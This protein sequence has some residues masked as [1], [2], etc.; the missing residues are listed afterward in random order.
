M[1]VGSLVDEKRHIRTSLFEV[2]QRGINDETELK[3]HRLESL[4]CDEERR[5]R[6]AYNLALM[7]TLLSA[8]SFFMEVVSWCIG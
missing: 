8:G 4:L 2:E 3:I 1:A 7:A 5:S 6:E